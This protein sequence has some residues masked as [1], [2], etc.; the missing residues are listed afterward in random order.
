MTARLES[1]PLFMDVV[2]KERTREIG[3]EIAVGAKRVHILSQFV[4]E[5]LFLSLLGG[6]LGLLLS[7]GI[8]YAMS[9]VNTS[10]GPMQFLGRPILS[11][12]IMLF[13]VIVLTLIGLF[14]GVFP[15][16]RAAG[17]DPVESLRYE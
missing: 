13:T 2:V 4:F 11:I 14:A 16:R 17:V 9:F 12:G 15:A 10:S 1:G 8:V 5:A 3:I 7:W 6:T